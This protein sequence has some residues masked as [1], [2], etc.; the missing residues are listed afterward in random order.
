MDD[1][2]ITER[3]KRN[4][5]AEDRLRKIFVD[6]GLD[7]DGP[8]PTPTKFFSAI[9]SKAKELIL[10]TLWRMEQPDLNIGHSY[11]ELIDIANTFIFLGYKIRS[12]AEERAQSALDKYSES[13]K[14]IAMDERK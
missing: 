2:E 10:L 9:R 14:K 4:Q 8:T 5:E 11:G 6:V 12:V 3:I 1:L 7:P 13:E